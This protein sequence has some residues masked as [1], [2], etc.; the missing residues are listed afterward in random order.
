MPGPMPAAGVLAFWGTEQNAEE[1][2]GQ[3]RSTNTGDPGAGKK[4]EEIVI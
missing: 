3:Y 2:K 4:A 1:V